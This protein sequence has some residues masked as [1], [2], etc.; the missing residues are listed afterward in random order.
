VPSNLTKY[1]TY[2][3]LHGYSSFQS[4]H[5]LHPTACMQRPRSPS[6][7][8]VFKGPFDS[9]SRPGKARGSHSASPE[10]DEDADYRLALRLS[11]ELNGDQ[12]AT[13][14]AGPGCNDDFDYALA[15]ELQYGSFVEAPMEELNASGPSLESGWKGEEPQTASRHLQNSFSISSLLNALCAD[16]LSFDQNS[17]SARCSKIGG[18]RRRHSHLL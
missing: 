6:T 8:A 17:M 15:L 2:R 4:S 16:R 9:M 18:M 10:H 1:E 3:L 14:Y 12:A 7:R 13:S 5:S 11:E